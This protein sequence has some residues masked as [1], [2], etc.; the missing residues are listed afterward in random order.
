MN[1]LKTSGAVALRDDLAQLLEQRVELARGRCRASA[2]SIRTGARLSMRSS[3]S[4]RNT[5][6]RLRSRS[7]RRPRTFCRSRCSTVS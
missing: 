7:S 3:V 5:M 2:G 1:W 6:N 4:E